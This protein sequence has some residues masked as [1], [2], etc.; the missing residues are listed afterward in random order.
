MPG[1]LHRGGRRGQRCQPGWRHG[2]AGRR[3]RHPGHPGQGR[4]LALLRRLGLPALAALAAA[5][6]PGPP[7]QVKSSTSAGRLLESEASD[8]RLL[9]FAETGQHMHFMRRL[10]FPAAACRDRYVHPAGTPVGNCAAAL[11]V[12]DDSPALYLPPIRHLVRRLHVV[13]VLILNEGI[14]PRLS[15]ICGSPS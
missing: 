5:Q 14:A 15:C 9:P 2:A 6:A 8:I 13:L 12:H 11:H 1:P 7:A 10:H 4:S 3:A